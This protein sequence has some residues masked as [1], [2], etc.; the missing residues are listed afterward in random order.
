LDRWLKNTE[1]GIDKEP[2]VSLFVMGTNDWLHG[3]A[4]PLAGTKMTKFYL[5]SKGD[6]HTHDGKGW[7]T[8]ELPTENGSTPD[9]YT[10]D[11]GDPTPADP[12]ERKD[13]LIY[14][15]QPMT[16]PLTIAGPMSAVLYASSSAKDTDWIL[17]LAKSDRKGKALLLGTGIIRARYRESF[18]EPKL[19][20]PN[21]LYEYHLDMWHTGVTV[22][23]G[24]RLVLVVS[25]ALF[26]KFSRNLNTGGH[27]E[28]ETNYVSAKQ[29][30]YHEKDYPSH[31]L[32]PVIPDPV[33]D[34]K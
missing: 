24:E 3:N 1:N 11:P 27:N 33:F 28:T 10:Y 34:R 6:A 18:S 20:E 8:T 26:P 32:L 19:L 13:I 12:E 7:L 2:L 22:D 29:T 31:I 30:I 16:E 25:S 17:R 15:T 21:K 14:K 23:E 5:A 4:Y 9:I